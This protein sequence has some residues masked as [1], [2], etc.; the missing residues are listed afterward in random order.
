MLLCVHRMLTWSRACIAA[1]ENICIGTWYA[2]SAPGLEACLASNGQYCIAESV[3]LQFACCAHE[4]KLIMLSPCPHPCVQYKPYLVTRH[5]APVHGCHC[6]RKMTAPSRKASG[7]NPMLRAYSLQ[8]LSGC[9]QHYCMA[10]VKLCHC[11][12]PHQ[13][14][15]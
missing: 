14:H 2:C 1:A 12:A 5:L 11:L 10:V 7:P 13:R 3:S 8:S 9:Q 15:G 4:P 6:A